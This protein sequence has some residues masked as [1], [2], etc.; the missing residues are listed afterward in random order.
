[1]VLINHP[2][3]LETHIELDPW[4]ASALNGRDLRG[5]VSAPVGKELLH[6][7]GAQG[8]VAG[9]ADPVVLAGRHQTVVDVEGVLQG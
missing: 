9:I 7:E 2:G 6:P 4:L 3:D 1:M 5:E 8:V